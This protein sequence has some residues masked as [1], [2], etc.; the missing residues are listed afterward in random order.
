[1]YL[2]QID[3]LA[4]RAFLKRAGTLGLA[5]VAAPWA[6][7]L[8]SISDAAAF[9]AT[10]Y[11]ALVCVFLYGG[12][13]FANTIIPFDSVNYAKYNAIR[14]GLQIPQASLAATALTPNTPLPGGMQLALAPA[15]SPLKSL[16]DAG[17]LAVQL[18]VGPLIQP[19]TLAQYTANAVPLPPKLFSHNDQQSVWQSSSPEG[20]TV[21]WGGRLGDLA[22]SNN[23][24][25]SFTCM[26]VAG[27]AVYLAGQTAIPYDVGT[28][29]PVAINGVIS[30]VYGST[31]CGAAMKSLMTQ[32]RSQMLEN[33]YNKVTSRSISSQSTVSS[34]FI[35]ASP[36][37]QTF[38]STNSLAAQ[39]QAVAKIIAARAN[40]GA[41]RQVFMVSL[42]GFDTHDF[43]MSQHVPLLSKVADA[44]SSFYTAT[45]QLG[46]SDKVTT[47]TASEF[48]RTYASNGDGSDHGWG[49]H[50]LVMGGAVNGKNFYGT[51]PEISV[52]GSDQ[53]GQG[54]L[55]PTTS[56]D[57]FAATLASWFG[58]AA[59]DLSLVVPNINNYSVKNMGFV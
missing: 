8:A 53:V 32:S 36:F 44:M 6:M 59:S 30:D 21:G 35:G 50:H 27:N 54:R 43:L 19:T 42:T 49:S 29:G 14:T 26:S 38:T 5:G 16:F 48:G 45:Q 47:F 3:K 33:E 10:D 24:N 20:S 23:T 4:R 2:N 37:A 40:F 28:L 11:K 22:L 58:V 57:Q 41:K 1:M 31:A 7:N 25:A 15:L 9:S 46:I 55:L 51:A 52:T 56:V 12:N 39:L 18:N 17:K 13:D 34:A